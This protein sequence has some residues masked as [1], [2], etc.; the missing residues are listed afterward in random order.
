MRTKDRRRRSRR[1]ITSTLQ[2]HWQDVAGTDCFAVGTGLDVSDGGIR[3]RTRHRIQPPTA[4]FVRLE[5]GDFSGSAVVRYCRPT[6]AAGD[7]IGLQ[8]NNDDVRFLRSLALLAERVSDSRDVRGGAIPDLA[9]TVWI[10]RCNRVEQRVL[11]LCPH[12]I[13]EC[14]HDEESREY[15]IRLRVTEDSSATALR[16]PDHELENVD[17]WTKRVRMAIA[18]IQSPKARA[19][20]PATPSA[21]PTEPKW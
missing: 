8:F 10:S 9:K 1:R 16:I 2:I 18:D 6:G 15:V 4:V 19:P 20:S 3:I 14:R 13:V 12:V 11:E 5:R 7:E 21:S 17:E